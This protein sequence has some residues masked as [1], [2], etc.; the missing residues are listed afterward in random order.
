MY[1]D[2][3]LAGADAIGAAVELQQSL[4]RMMERGGFNLTKRGI[5]SK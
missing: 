5:T 2:A 4:D 1:V 3:C